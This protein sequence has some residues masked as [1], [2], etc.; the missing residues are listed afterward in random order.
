VLQLDNR[1]YSLEFASIVGSRPKTVA[2]KMSTRKRKQ[3]EEEELQ[4]LPS[5]ESEEEEE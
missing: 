2:R 3:D 5:D 4:A 1:V